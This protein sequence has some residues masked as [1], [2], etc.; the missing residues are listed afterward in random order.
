MSFK[1]ASWKALI[2]AIGIVSMGFLLAVIFRPPK[3]DAV[4][5]FNSPRVY[6]PLF[7]VLFVFFVVVIWRDLSKR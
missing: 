3:F 7:I 4:V 1:T 6:I 5:R 2:A